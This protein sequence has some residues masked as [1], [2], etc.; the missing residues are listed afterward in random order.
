MQM[1]LP[2][3]SSTPELVINTGPIIAL[4]AATHS[5]DWLGSLYQNVW[6]PEE[7]YDELLAGGSL[8]PE[9][10]LV[11]GAANVVRRLPAQVELPLS[12]THE[13]DPGEASVI[14]TALDRRIAT[15]AI[16][17]KTGRRVARLHGLKVTGSLGILVR[18]KKEGLISDLDQCIR[19]MRSEGIWLATD[20][21]RKALAEVGEDASE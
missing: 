6:M 20:L 19:R 17:E 9:P 1:S 12:L 15:V 10:A 5:L 4:V 21:T 7:V 18:A 13:L 2:M 8:S 14:Q 3:K 16:D 11:R